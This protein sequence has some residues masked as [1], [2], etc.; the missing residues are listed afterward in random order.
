MTDAH[1]PAIPRWRRIRCQAGAQ[2]VFIIRVDAKVRVEPANW[3]DHAPTNDRTGHDD[4]H[5]PEWR[6]GHPAGVKLLPPPTDDIAIF[7]DDSMGRV[8]HADRWLAAKRATSRSS[9]PSHRG[10]RSPGR[11][12]IRHGPRPA[13]GSVPQ[14][15]RHALATRI[16]SLVKLIAPVLRPAV[17]NHRPQ[18]SVPAFD[19]IGPAAADRLGQEVAAVVGRQDDTDQRAVRCVRKHTPPWEHKATGADTLPYRRIGIISAGALQHDRKK[20][21]KAKRLPRRQSLTKLPQLPSPRAKTARACDCCK[22]AIFIQAPGTR[23]LQ[24]W[25]TGYSKIYVPKLTG[26]V[27][28]STMVKSPVTDPVVVTVPVART[29]PMV[30]DKD[31]ELYMV[32]M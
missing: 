19:T 13:P 9:L 24:H 28:V 15:L 17:R 14:P 1:R 18:R 2:P 27:P 10:R 3:I 29:L 5:G 23:D 16:V 6:L 8:D 22:S 21:Q 31:V 20:T 32:K 30:D 26:L 25:V 7:V 12:S 11:R 4:E